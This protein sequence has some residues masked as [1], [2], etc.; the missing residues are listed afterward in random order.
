MTL[1]AFAFM[2]WA[3]AA[4]ALSALACGLI[5]PFVR[6]R[7]LAFLVGAVAHSALAGLGAAQYFGVSPDLGALPAAILSALLIGWLDD[8]GRGQGQG[9]EDALIG[10]IWAVGM[11]IGILFISR[12]P[13]YNVQLLSYLFGSIL[14]AGPERLWLMGAGLAVVSGTLV[15]LWRPMVAVAL[16]REFAQLRGLPVAWLDRLLLVLIAIAVVLLIKVVGLILVLALLTLPAAVAAHWARS[17]AWM[18][19]VATV[20][21]LVSVGVGMAVAI[22]LD[23][24]AGPTM[25]LAA[26]SVFAFS[27][28]VRSALVPQRVAHL[29]RQEAAVETSV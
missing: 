29:S 16:D 5:G 19:A 14:T 20:A 23:W 26:A 2:R 24:P 10:A 9:H 11:A 17:M 28:L 25:I 7:R 18:V 6:V 27:M 3:I 13:G 1:L 4:G 8:R 12:T 15:V 22:W 21:S